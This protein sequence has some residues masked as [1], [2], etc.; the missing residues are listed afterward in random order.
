MFPARLHRCRR[1]HIRAF[2]VAQH[3][4]HMFIKPARSFRSENQYMARIKARTIHNTARFFQLSAQ[5]GILRHDDI[6]LLHAIRTRR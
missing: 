2:Y 4:C 3:V 5:L 6:P 1:Y